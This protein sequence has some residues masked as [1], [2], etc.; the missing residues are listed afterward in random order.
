[1][2]AEL[3]PDLLVQ[4]RDEGIRGHRAGMIRAVVA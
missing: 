2:R 3:V 1:V 4:P